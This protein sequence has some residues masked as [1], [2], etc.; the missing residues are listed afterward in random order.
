MRAAAFLL[1]VPAILTSSFALA[2]TI[3]TYRVP[4]GAPGSDRFRVMVEGK[5]SGVFAS[6]QGL[7]FTIFKVIWYG[8]GRHDLKNKSLTL[9]SGQTL[10][11]S[12]GAYLANVRSL[13]IK[14]AQEVRV[15]G[16]GVLAGPTRLVVSRHVDIEGIIINPSRR[17][18]MNKIDAS[19]DVPLGLARRQERAGRARRH[20]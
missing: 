13:L 7:A 12:G 14:N 19:Q 15:R 3:D 8:P 16:R 4:A 20:G 10:Y 2:A 18:W 5:V 1:A 11:V 9:S 17:T 6:P